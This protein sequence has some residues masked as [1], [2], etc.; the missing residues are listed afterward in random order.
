MKRSGKAIYKLL[1]SFLSEGNWE[2]DIAVKATGYMRKCK[3]SPHLVV[4]LD[5]TSCSKI[6]PKEVAG[7]LTK[8]FKTKNLR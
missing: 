6:Q 2:E 7:I 4:T 3:I 5:R 1:K 8:H